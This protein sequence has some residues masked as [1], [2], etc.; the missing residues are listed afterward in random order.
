MGM[1]EFYTLIVLIAFPALRLFSFYNSSTIS[2]K[3]LSGV[4]QYVIITFPSADTSGGELNFTLFFFN[5]VYKLLIFFT[6]IEMCVYPSLS[7]KKDFF[8]FLV[9]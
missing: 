1:I 7:V 8:F 4:K 9:G 6:V 3:L 5:F 2:R